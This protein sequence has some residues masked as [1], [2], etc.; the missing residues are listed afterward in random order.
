MGLVMFNLLSVI[1]TAIAVGHGK[2][3]LANEVSTYHLAL[4]ISETWK[5]FRI[6]LTDQEFEKLEG[7]RRTLAQ[8]ATRLKLLGKRVNPE[9]ISKSKRCPKKPPP[10]RKSGNRGNHV[11]T[12]RILEKRR[13]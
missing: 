5:G 4:E 2:P 12:A 11:A 13:S 10:K 6:A 7:G 8:L 3:E 9:Q 1:K